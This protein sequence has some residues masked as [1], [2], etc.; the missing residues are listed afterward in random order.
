MVIHPK[1]YLFFILSV[2]NTK[3]YD[4]VGGERSTSDHT[5]HWQ[6]LNQSSTRGIMAGLVDRA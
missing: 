3:T 6:V 2:G 4:L 5:T 1:K